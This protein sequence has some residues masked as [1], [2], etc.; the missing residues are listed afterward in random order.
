MWFVHVQIHLPCCVYAGSF[1]EVQ[2]IEIKIEAEAD[3]NDATECSQ[4]DTPSTGMF[5]VSL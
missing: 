3:I 4:D 2:R 5:A 1:M